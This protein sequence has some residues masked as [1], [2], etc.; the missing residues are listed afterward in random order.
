MNDDEQ[1]EVERRVIDVQWRARMEANFG[2][3][4]AS[5]EAL[6][7]DADVMKSDVLEIKNF[8]AALSQL[9]KILK[10]FSATI[11]F[12]AGIWYFVKTGDYTHIGK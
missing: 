2:Q 7:K 3:M 5:I 6:R 10:F 4:E 8:M 1:R 11:A 12:V 9:P